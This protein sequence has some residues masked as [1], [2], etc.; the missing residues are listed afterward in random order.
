M[1]PVKR[2]K[3]KIFIGMA[4][5][6]GK[7]YRMLEEAQA[8]KQE[9]TDVVIGVLETHGR[10]ETADKAAGLEI[11]PRQQIARGGLILTEMDTDAILKRCLSTSRYGS[12]PQLVL[13]DELAH[14]NVPG[15][16]REKRYEDVEIILAAGIDV[17]STMNV[18]HLESLNDVVAKI[19]SVVVRERV[20]D[21]ILKEADEVV[22][23]D[24][25]PETLQERLI[26]GK[27]YAP[28]KIQQSLDN[29]FQRRNLI[30]LRELA[31]REV[32]D[33]VEE[34]AIPGV[35]ATT[36]NGQFCNI[37]ERVLVCV[38]TYPQS[39]QLLRRGARLANYMNAPLYVVFVANPEHFLT[40][41]ESLHIDTCEKLCKE[42]AG[43]FIRVTSGDIGTAIAQV[44]EQY[45]ITQIVIGESQRS[46]WQILLKG[47]LT[48]KLVR[49]LKNIDLH[50]IAT[51]KTP[52]ARR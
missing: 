36:P 13:V 27:I 37:H 25:T 38:S 22:V 9:G 51:E 43:T 24:V 45:R 20:P 16:P 19:T 40:K 5:G 21:R 32:A 11:I 14:T 29:F 39:L 34:E 31:L 26:E 8:L 49:L 2:G 7:T 52:S 42:F 4:P 15:S 41:E 48:H 47:S 44:A 46:R 23:V 28:Q 6:V 1:Y 18:Q 17:Y 35:N 3:H 33:N 10:K 50:I 12:I 30:A